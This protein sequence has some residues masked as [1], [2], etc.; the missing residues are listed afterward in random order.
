MVVG[1]TDV[2]LGKTTLPSKRKQ[3]IRI[4]KNENADTEIFHYS[5]LEFSLTCVTSYVRFPFDTNICEVLFHSYSYTED[6]FHIKMKSNADWM[7]TDHKECVTKDRDY[8]TEIIQLDRDE[9]IFSYTP[10]MNLT[11]SYSVAGFK[12]KFVRKFKRYMLIYYLPSTLFV[13]I[14]WTSF[15]IP[16]TS[17]PARVGLLIT[18]LLVLINIYN[19]VPVSY[20]HLTLPTKA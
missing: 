11:Y 4:T 9:L 12:L 3:G 20:T 15:F 10:N 14:S 19:N 8:D 5:N 18:T 7:K 6:V 16:P 1:T 17:Y 2:N 13:I